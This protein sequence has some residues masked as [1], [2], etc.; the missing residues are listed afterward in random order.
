MKS[1]LI[2]TP[3]PTVEEFARSIGVSPKRTREL[4]RLAEAIVAGDL[5]KKRSARVGGAKNSATVS[6]RRS[7]PARRK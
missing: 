4:V 5:D 1:V 7:K 3:F 2:T 6:N